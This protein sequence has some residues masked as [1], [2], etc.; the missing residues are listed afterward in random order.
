VIIFD[1]QNKELK[2]FNQIEKIIHLKS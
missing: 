1:D 2:K